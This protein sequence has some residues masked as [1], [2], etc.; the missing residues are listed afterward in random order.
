MAPTTERTNL[1]GVTLDLR[2]VLHA[3]CLIG[4]ESQ[5]AHAVQ[6]VACI[7]WC[8]P[9]DSLKAGP[10]SLNRLAKQSRR[11]SIN[12]ERIVRQCAPPVGEPLATRLA[13]TVR[14]GQRAKTTDLRAERSTEPLGACR[15]PPWT[16]SPGR[17]TGRS[18]DRDDHDAA[19]DRH[20][21]PVSAPPHSAD[22]TRHTSALPGPPEASGRVCVA[23]SRR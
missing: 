6:R 15:R 9:P 5:P 22:G 19:H 20:G 14:H 7:V 2:S 18:R 13:R 12:D 10:V 11:G 21:P 4:V 17:S 16:V 1:P 8:R 3:L 23:V